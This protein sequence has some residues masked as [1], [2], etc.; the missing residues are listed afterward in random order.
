MKKQ[1]LL[2]IFGALILAGCSDNKGWNLKGE[3]PEGVETVFLQAPNNFGGWYTLDSAR[4]EG[5]KY[6]FSEPRANSQIYALKLGENTFYVPADS[7]ETITVTADGRRSGSDEA[8]IFNAVESVVKSGGSGRDIL[9]A[10]DGKYASTAAYYATRL[11]KDRSLLRTVTNRYS[12]ERPTDPRTAILR[13]EFEKTMPKG[14]GEV[15]QQVIYADEIGYYDIELMDRNG[16]MRKLSEV[17]DANPLT[18][19]AYVDFTSEE[20]PAITLAL[21]ETNSAGAAIYEVGFAENQHLWAV[22]SEA[23]PWVS[24][25][26]SDAADS[27]HLGSYAVNSLPTFFIIKNGEIV[28]RVNDYTKLLQTLNSYK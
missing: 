5:G 4:V 16:K 18:V 23:L 28:D 22:D 14:T 1:T 25:Y 3:A 11:T 19:L 24:V 17:V 7:T 2:Y 9:K 21:G 15:Q 26:Q 8:E 10:L 27:S 20:T 12:E 13:S 6:S